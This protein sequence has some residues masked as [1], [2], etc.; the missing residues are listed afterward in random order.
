MATAPGWVRQL[1]FGISTVE[2]TFAR[3][4]FLPGNPA[5]RERFERIG[6]GFLAGYHAA[7]RENLVV[8]LGR[9]LDDVDPEL[10]GFAYEGAAMALALRDAFSVRR[11]RL[12]IFFENLADPCVYTAHV[13]VGWAQARLPAAL[14]ARVSAED[15]L[16]RWLA[17]DGTGFH[18]GYFHWRRTIR[19]RKAPAQQA[20]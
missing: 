16:L 15:P 1:V 13:G 9:R 5:R 10:R 2:V 20:R 3:R 18:E 6:R 4:G 12:R 8:A 19:D 7:V 17:V 11:R 14:R